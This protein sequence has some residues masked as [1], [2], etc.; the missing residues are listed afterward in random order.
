[1]S[2]QTPLA[3]A[4]CGLLLGAGSS[5]IAAASDAP[6]VEA[7]LARCA[8]ISSSHERLACYDL[9]SGRRPEST[10]AAPAPAA[11]PVVTTPM[12]APAKEDFGLTQA[13]KEKSGAPTPPKIASIKGT[14]ASLGQSGSGRMLVF[15]DNGQNWELD[16]PDPLLAVGNVVTI[17]RG[18]LGAFLLTTP[19]KRTHH[20]KRI[21]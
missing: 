21:R 1:M 16:S 8:G 20:A 7:G 14:V 12:A 19:S 9:L 2:R 15:L 5:N 11:P 3:I 18:A 6:G 17:D 10:K 13:Q 4:I